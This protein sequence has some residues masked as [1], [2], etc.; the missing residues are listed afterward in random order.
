MADLK[1]KIIQHLI[2]IPGFRTNRKI[3]V[4]ESDDWGM[5]RMASQESY[6]R[7]LKKGYPVDQCIYNLNDSLE[8]NEDL[9]GLMEVL[10]SVKDI[11]GNPAK[12]TMNNIVA[13]PDFERIE[14]SGYSEY[15]YE[16]F[17][18]TLTTYKNSDKVLELYHEGI[19]KNLFQMQFHGREHV[20]I[21]RWIESLQLGNK[22]LRDAFTEKM[23]TVASANSESGRSDYLDAFGMAYFKETETL[24]S[25]VSS[26]LS[27]FNHI[28]GFYSTSFI[29]PCYI[30]PK[31]MELILHQNNIK[32]IQGGHAQLIPIEGITLKTKQQY[33][34]LGQSNEFGMKYLVR[35]VHFEPASLL[36]KAESEVLN[37]LQQIETAFFWGKPA[38]IS[39][40]RVNFMGRIRPENRSVNLKLLGKLLTEIKRK[41]PDVEFMSSDEL[42]QL[43]MN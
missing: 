19:A 10:D 30:Y 27:L 40:H 35:N 14:A 21:N 32:F 2:N 25:I 3:V 41:Y 34:Y 38:I 6:N 20:N 15:H 29:A 17:T 8:S 12:M 39:T 28:W 11:N 31:S 33:H 43:I 24:L 4:L 5:I 13:N 26:G 18:K 22:V 16:P 36:D 37:S 1:R 7:L 9:I 23:F 42:G